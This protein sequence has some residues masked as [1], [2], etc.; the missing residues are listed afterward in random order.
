MKQKEKRITSD[1]LLLVEGKDEAVFFDEIFQHQDVTGVQIWDGGGEDKFKST[2]HY[3]SGS[4][5]FSKVRSLG[6]VRD[7]ERNLANSAFTMHLLH[8]EEIFP[9]HTESCRYR[10]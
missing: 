10:H 1:R 5:G 7:A 3:L 6:I 2:F 4:D 8:P 9:A